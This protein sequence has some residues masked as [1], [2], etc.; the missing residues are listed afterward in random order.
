VSSHA[1]LYAVRICGYG[2]VRDFA[3]SD[4]NATI[5]RLLVRNLF[6]LRFRQHVEDIVTARADY[7]LLDRAAARVRIR[8][9]STVVRR[10]MQVSPSR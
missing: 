3:F 4:G 1:W 8:L 9:S 7:S 5:A 10:G 6:R 2:W